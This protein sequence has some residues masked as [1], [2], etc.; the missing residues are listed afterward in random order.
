MKYSAD[1]MNQQ[2]ALH[3]AHPEY[4][5]YG[6]NWAYLVAGIRLIQNCTTVLDYGC[7]KGSLGA[8]LRRFQ[9][10]CIDY[11]PMLE[12][13]KQPPLPC[14]LVACID[15]L[16]HIEPDCLDEVVADLARLTKRILFVAVCLRPS[17]QTLRDGRNAHLLLESKSWWRGKVEKHG[18]QVK[19]DW[20]EHE[21]WWVAMLERS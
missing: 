20:P 1:Y 7:G 19:R 11:D 4:G 2:V 10:P 14:D 12:R 8:L 21:G 18:L 15:V 3:A 16:E 9:I 5:N 6:F 13:F 17:S